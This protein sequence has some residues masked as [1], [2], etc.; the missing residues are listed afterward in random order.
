MIDE[1]PVI[2][3]CLEI[4]GDSSTIAAIASEAPGLG[5]QET[6]NYQELIEAWCGE[7]GV[8]FGEVY[9][10]GSRGLLKRHRRP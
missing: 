10:L 8:D 7:N 1:M 3:D 2:G 6:R 5:T 4:E 9:G